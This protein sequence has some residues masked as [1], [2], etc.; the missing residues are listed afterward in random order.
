MADVDDSAKPEVEG[1]VSQYS[2]SEI[3]FRGKLEADSGLT[4]S[5]KVELEGNTSGD[6]IDESQVTVGGSFGQ[7]TLGSE[8]HVASLMHYGNKDA[9]V[10]L[11]CGDASFIAGVISCARENN[12][13]LGTAGWLI[14]GDD[15]KVSYISPRMEGVQ[16]GASYIPNTTN[17]DKAGAPADNDSD[18]W[19]IALNVQRAIGEASIAASAGHYQASQMAADD[20]TFSNFGL[21]VGFGSVGFDVAYATHDGG[22]EMAKER[23]YEVASAGVNY[24]DGPLTLSLSHMTAEADDSSE[25]NATMLSMAYELAPGVASRT[26]IISADQDTAEGTAFVTGI[27]L[28]F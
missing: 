1:G 22:D 26:S 19:S 8:D 7:I 24:S 28:G 4:F 11:N 6:T 10:G 21:Q 12:K 3:F 9:G 17:E 14:G 20:E 2:D 13:G 5:V 15:H 16:F 25:V 18:A 27:T 23:D